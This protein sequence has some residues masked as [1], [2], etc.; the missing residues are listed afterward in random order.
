MTEKE[1]IKGFDFFY[2]ILAICPCPWC[3]KTPRFWIFMGSGETYLIEIECIN[4]NCSVK[5]KGKIVPIRKSQK[6]SPNEIQQRIIRCLN[7]W[8]KDN[9]IPAYEAIKISPQKIAAEGL[10]YANGTN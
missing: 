4:E 6:K 5:P 1:E 7:F 9:P 3:K 10:P 8:N 2:E